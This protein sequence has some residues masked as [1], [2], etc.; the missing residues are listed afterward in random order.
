M[1]NKAYFFTVFV[2]FVFIVV[3]FLVDIHSP[4]GN[5]IWLLYIIPLLVLSAQDIT[6]IYILSVAAADSIFILIKLLL[7]FNAFD[8][9]EEIFNVS[10][11]LITI[12]TIA[13]L[14]IQRKKANSRLKE[15]EILFRSTFEQSY[16]GTGHIGEN[17]RYLRL[18]R[19]YCNILGYSHEELYSRTF[20]DITFAEDFEKELP[21][22]RKLREGAIESYS[23]EKRF[24]LKNGNLLWCL[25]TK[26][27][28]YDS[29][30]N[31]RFYITTIED[32]SVRK[33]Y[34]QAIKESEE[35]FRR[36]IEDSPI[37]IMIHAEDGEVTLVNDAW[38][39]LSGY[40]L[41]DIPTISDWTQKAYGRKKGEMERYIKGLYGLKGKNM[42]LELTVRTR[43]GRQLIWQFYSAPLGNLPDGRRIV[44]SM[45]MDITNRRI[46]EENL[47]QSEESFRLL[48]DS[49]PQIVWSTDPDGWVV[50]YN[51]RWI[52]YTGLSIEE[53]T[54]WRWVDLIHPD[55]RQKTMEI[56]QNALSNMKDYEVEHR[57][58]SRDGNYCWFLSRGIPMNEGGKIVKWFGA[59][60]NIN[61]QKTT[62]EELQQA[63]IRLKESE[64]KLLDAQK[65]AHIGSFYFDIITNKVEWSEEVYRIFEIDMKQ[66]ALSFDNWIEHTHPMDR[67]NLLKAIDASIRNQIPMAIEYRILTAKSRI[68]YVATISQPVFDSLGNAVKVFGTLMDITER[69][70]AQDRLEKIL[71][72][73]ERSNAE[74]EQFAYV[75]SHDLQE[76]LRMIHSYS[77]LLEKRYKGKIDESADD[78]LQFIT[79]GAKRMQH[80]INDL[81]QYSRVTTRG[82]PFETVDCMEVLSN[83]LDNLQISIEESGA[84]ITYDSL[85]VVRADETQ[86]V[87]LFQNLLSNSIK[88]SDKKTPEIHLRAE[89]KENEW[90]FSVSDN[91]IGINPEF[92][93]RIFIIFQRLHDKDKYPGT[94]IG[95]AICKKIVERHQG[96]IWVESELKKGTT[97][98]FTLPKR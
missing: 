51:K 73:L 76:P 79:G 37:P 22:F 48:A 77:E 14:Q 71:K 95:L 16:I 47:R 12:L 58:R 34:E 33:N 82:K 98:Y 35:R 20:Q 1:K 61:E 39:G 13:Y 29:D 81:L 10:L 17:L 96:R 18:N 27:R 26:S 52:E 31:F 43:D 3:V 21:F 94:G 41:E 66:P 57:L 53:S 32:I 56:W 46:I 54:G 63:L 86:L 36:A 15:S 59:S 67:E 8:A 62:Q 88:F 75:A 5:S 40:R 93:D 2:N 4:L 7:T 68:R 84:R 9:G 11:Y 70:L 30:G 91:G 24:V 19:Q 83:V 42:D 6:I 60:T 69:K 23:I 97:F 45:A 92:Y 89:Q 49:L 78:F 72:E 50:Y 25:N 90:V 65:L 28:A 74:L 44:I 64:T 80:L 55:D 38:T 85:P 87:Q